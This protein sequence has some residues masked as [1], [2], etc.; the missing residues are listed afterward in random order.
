VDLKDNGEVKVLF[1]NR[2]NDVELIGR[3]TSMMYSFIDGYIYYNNNIIKIR[4]DL[5]RDTKKC[6]DFGEYEVFDYYS[7]IIQLK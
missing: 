6:K 4:Y 5:I 3:L 2:V 7:D 1:N